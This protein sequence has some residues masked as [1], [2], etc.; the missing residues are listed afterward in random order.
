MGLYEFFF[1]DASEAE[2]LSKIA[3]SH[4]RNSRLRARESVDARQQNYQMNSA[5]VNLENDVGT[6]A[7]IL[8]TILKMLDEKGQIS[9]ADLKEK[10][11]DLDLLD[12][13]RDGRIDVNVLRE[14]AFFDRE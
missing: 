4:E 6:L 11:K 10:L 1:S 14:G 13:I 2:S 5:L 7:L 12:G 3:K 8:A 9:R